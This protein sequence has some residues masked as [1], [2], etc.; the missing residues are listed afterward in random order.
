MV[1]P[2]AAG[3]AM[4]GSNNKCTPGV[5]KHDCVMQGLYHAPQCSLQLF[6]GSWTVAVWLQL[7]GYAYC[8][9]S[10]AR[11]PL[12]TVAPI[13]TPDGIDFC[14]PFAQALFSRRLCSCVP[15]CAVLQMHTAVAT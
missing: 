3:D 14:F 13:M 11:L 7:D 12:E 1:C 6:C 9:T 10:N 8:D 4:A 2:S 15:S 5:L